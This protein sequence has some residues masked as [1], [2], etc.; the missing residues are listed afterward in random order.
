MSI[1]MFIVPTP[2][3]ISNQLFMLFLWGRGGG[4]LRQGIALLHTENLRVL[5]LY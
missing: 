3:T 1:S 2:V 4:I 5:L